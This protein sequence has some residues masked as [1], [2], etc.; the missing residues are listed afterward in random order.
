MKERLKVLYQQN[1][2]PSCGQVFSIQ[3]FGNTR[4]GWFDLYGLLRRKK[5]KV[6]VRGQSVKQFMFGKRAEKV[7]KVYLDAAAEKKI[8]TFIQLLTLKKEKKFPLFF[9]PPC[10]HSAF[11]CSPP[12]LETS[13]ENCFFVERLFHSLSLSLGE[14]LV[15][16]CVLTFCQSCSFFSTCN[17]IRFQ[18]YPEVVYN[19]VHNTVSPSPRLP[20]SLNNVCAYKITNE[21]NCVKCEE[22]GRCSTYDGCI[23]HFSM[24]F[25]LRTIFFMLI[26]CTQ[27][28]AVRVWKFVQCVS[29]WSDVFYNDVM[30][31][32]DNNNK[33]PLVFRVFS[34]RQFFFLINY[35]RST[36]RHLALFPAPQ[37]RIL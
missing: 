21:K 6:F 34:S 7:Q 8:T 28:G 3:I 35:I 25:F 1:L 32:V 4:T 29:I 18:C 19:F 16:I 27:V 11:F 37:T 15:C 36:W 10:L 9:F 22:R 17:L 26:K 20:P 2:L 14:L 24:Y 33:A 13:L 12:R 5:V 30:C 31:V 23:S